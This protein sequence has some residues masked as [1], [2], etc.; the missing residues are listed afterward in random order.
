VSKTPESIMVRCGASPR[1]RDVR[2]SDGLFE[3][4]AVVKEDEGVAEFGLKSVFYNGLKG[5]EGQAGP[6]PG[7]VQWLHQQYDKVLMESAVRNVTK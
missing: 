1:E 4:T 2:E 6:M 3:M 5:H 7:H